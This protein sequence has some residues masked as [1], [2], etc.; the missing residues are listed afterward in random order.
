LVWAKRQQEP[1]D[2]GTADISIVSTL[3]LKKEE[4][5]GIKFD[6]KEYDEIK[7]VQ[8]DDIVAPSSGYHSALKRAVKDLLALRTMK[9]LYQTINNATNKNSNTSLEVNELLVNYFRLKSESTFES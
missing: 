2:H 6:D 4:I 1:S 9:R 3:N 7:W 8:P 5:I